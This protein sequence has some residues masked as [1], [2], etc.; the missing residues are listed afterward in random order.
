MQK[1]KVFS[2]RHIVTAALVVCLAA[3]VWLNMKFSSFENNAVGT[4]ENLSDTEYYDKDSN[5]GQAVETAT[6]V[7]KIAS[8]R[9]ERNNSRNKTV[10]D[11]TAIVNN[12]T[13]E[14]EAKEKAL[15]GLNLI[16]E[17]VNSETAMETVIKLKGFSDA[18]ALISEE[19]VTVIVP[20]ESLLT[21]Q[22]LQIQDAVTSQMA[23]D[24][25][26]IKI[27]AVK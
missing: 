24:L 3:A 11:L 1:G 27:I 9:L 10:A 25:E 22:T 15:K 13:A 6:G 16:A 14:A 2:K 23:I 4:G 20:A 18:L 7:D 26:K 8:A 5:L 21:S 12:S 17:Q 19:S